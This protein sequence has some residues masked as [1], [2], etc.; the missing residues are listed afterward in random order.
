M[1]IYNGSRDRF[2]GAT[3]NQ[4]YASGKTLQEST[5]H[6]RKGLSMSS[7]IWYLLS[8]LFLLF[9]GLL[10]V[11][12]TAII[13]QIAIVNISESTLYTSHQSPS[14]QSPIWLFLNL[15]VVLGSVLIVVGLPTVYIRLAKRA[16]WLGSVGLV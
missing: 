3:G 1:L 8:G 6:C 16:R 15:M 10:T 7:K 9:G 13:A 2:L 11:V 5:R 4:I 14:L 12:F